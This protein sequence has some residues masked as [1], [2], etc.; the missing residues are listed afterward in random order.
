VTRRVARALAEGQPLLDVFSGG[1][2]GPRHRDRFTA[3]QVDQIRRTVRR[4]PEVMI[5]VTGGARKL[6]AVAAHLAYISGNGDLEIETDEGERVPKE[7]QKALL[8]DWHLEL[9]AGQYRERT[10]KAARGVKLVHNIVLSMPSPTPPDKVLAAAKAF[11][12]EKCLWPSTKN[13]FSC[14]SPL[15]EP[16]HPGVKTPRVEAPVRPLPERIAGIDQVLSTHDIERITAAPSTVGYSRVHSR[17][18][19]RVADVAGSG[20]TSSD[21][22]RAMI[23]AETPEAPRVTLLQH[24]ALPCVL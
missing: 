19:A 4:T 1:R 15:H 20:P 6:G 7:G 24:V 21:G 9:S 17:Q 2:M 22:L 10:E 23:S 18:G 8:K 12:R 14:R 5:K 11:V 3:A 13:S 16:G